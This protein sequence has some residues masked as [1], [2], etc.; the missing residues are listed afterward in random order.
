MKGHV[1][2]PPSVVDL[3]VAKL[4][5]GREPN[6]RETLLDPGCGE[7]AFIEGVLRFCRTHRL[8]SPSIV[9]VEMNPVLV[10]E[11]KGR[12]HGGKG[13]EI[14]QADFLFHALPKFDY[15]I[16]NP[17]YVP[18]TGLS[19]EER[20]RYRANYV[21]AVERFDLYLLFF[22]RA[23]K[24]LAPKGRLCFITPEKFEYVHSATP[25][26][27][28]LGG[29]T[30][31]EVNHVS[32]DTFPGLVTYPTITTVV[33]SPPAKESQTRVALRDGKTVRA[34]LPRDGSS[35]NPVINQI[36]PSEPSGLTL[37]DLCLRVSCGI[38]TGAD[39]MYV[40]PRSAL[41]ELLKDFAH[42]TIAG[43]QLGPR[44]P[45]E[46]HTSNVM[47]IPYDMDGN[48]LP[49]GRMGPLLTFLSRPDIARHLKERT[50]VS[51]GGRE[52]Y[53]FHD[54]APLRD[55]LRP[56]ILC[57]DITRDPHFWL[58]S[59][60]KFVPR[61]SV[62][63]I[64]PKD[65]IDV[66][67]LLNYLNGEEAMAWLRGHCQKAANGFLRLQS[68]ILKQMPIP[69]EFGHRGPGDVLARARDSESLRLRNPRSTLLSYA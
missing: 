58:D 20:R 32:E 11:A 35:W 37:Q 39:S 43:R 42:P 17:P 7:G 63:Y 15:V 8:D 29:F 38:A 62:Y 25:L 13:V 5:H 40:H 27:R 10:D 34:R 44:G 60:G 66:A 18:I 24:L 2:T 68:T 69:A 1:P 46:V 53:R 54:N 36:E 61:H 33:G 28:L 3:M 48:L 9:G 57:K 16:G 55:I 19:P 59:A 47:L 31:E 65:G 30:V 56:K 49:E 22:E 21:T 6:P 41:P 14:V 50:C 26:R 52:W 64:V 23:L 45:T 12:L 67:R 4:F 51:L